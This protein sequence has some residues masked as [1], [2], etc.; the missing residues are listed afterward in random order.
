MR[1]VEH[2]LGRHEEAHQRLVR[3]WD[4]LPDRSTATAAALQIELAV[5]GL[6]ELDFEQ[7]GGDR[8]R[9]PGDRAGAR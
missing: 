3:A 5:D 7:I 4:D 6:Y 9:S 1:S 2:W 8:T